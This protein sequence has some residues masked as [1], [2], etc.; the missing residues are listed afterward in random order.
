MII[1]SP[2]EMVFR[3]LFY[4]LRAFAQGHD[5]F[6]KLGGIQCIRLHQDEDSDRSH[7]RIWNDAALVRRMKLSS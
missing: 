1:K 3:D 7:S 2:L 5:V 4:H 6:L